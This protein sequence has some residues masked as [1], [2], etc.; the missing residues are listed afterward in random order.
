[1][2]NMIEISSHPIYR[3]KY[4]GIID[5]YNDKDGDNKYSFIIVMDNINNEYDFICYDKND[6]YNQSMSE[7]WCCKTNVFIVENIKYLFCDETHESK[8]N[9]ILPVITRIC[10]E[11]SHNSGI[12]KTI[13][14]YPEKLWITQKTTVRDIMDKYVKSYRYKRYRVESFILNGNDNLSINDNIYQK[15]KEIVKEEHD[16]TE[17]NTLLIKLTNKTD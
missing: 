4:K 2:N 11:T 16:K 9:D 5:K 15:I 1:M 7:S 14:S 8:T 3:E 12:E 6:F 10:R 17:T 13:M